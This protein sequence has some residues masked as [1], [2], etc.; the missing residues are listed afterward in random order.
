MIKF[1]YSLD[2]LR[3]FYIIAQMRSYKK[4]SQYLGMPLSTLSRRI[5][6]LEDDLQLRLLNRDAHRVTLTNTGECY[7]N[8]CH[9]M[10]DEL[11]GIELDLAKEKDS[12]SGKIRIAAPIYSGKE[13]LKNIFSD[14]LLKY[15]DIQLDL[16]F[17]NNLIDIEELGIDIAFR[18]KNPSIDNWIAREL[19]FTRNILCC[20]SSQNLE[21]IAHPEQLK[22]YP[23]I[24]CFRLVPWQL[25]NKKTGEKYVYH[26][27]DFIRL[28]V[29]EVQIMTHAVKTGLGVSYIPDYLALPMIKKGELKQ[30][31]PNWQSEKKAFS[32]LY[33]DR[34]N[35][36]LRVRLFIEYTLANFPS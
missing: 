36:P 14:F 7:Y 27:N 9:S 2:D 1:N 18:M 25:K 32:M 20:A 17:S 22:E 11:N 19:K 10:F 8:R 26:P 33:R 16:R 35:I 28:E 4:A 30:I 21:H 12:P 5:R 13:Y 15:P 23:K 34:K 24:T 31:L 29:D 6:H 3:C